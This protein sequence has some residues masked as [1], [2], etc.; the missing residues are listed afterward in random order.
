MVRLMVAGSAHLDVIASVS[1]DEFTLDK[2]GTISIEVGGTACNIALNLLQLGAHVNFLTAMNNSPHAQFVAGYLGAQG[3]ELIIDKNQNL[4]L[5]AFSAHINLQG[6]LESAITATSIALHKFTDDRVE[7]ALRGV[8]AVVI[9]CNLSQETIWQIIRLATERLLPIFAAAVSEEKSLRILGITPALTAFFLNNRELSYIRNHLGS[10]ARHPSELNVKLG[11]TLVVTQGDQGAYIARPHCT[12][13][14]YIEAP[15]VDV[16]GNTLGMGDAFMAATVYGHIAMDQT[17]EQAA[18]AALPLVAQIA[19]RSNCNQSEEGGLD[20]VLHEMQSLARMDAMTGVLNRVS[21]EIELERMQNRAMR[22]GSPLSVAI[23]D[24]DFFK[25]VNDTYGH[26]QGDQ[27]IKRVAREMQA[28]VR[29]GDVVGRWGGEEFV[30][31]M[32]DSKIDEAIVA[33]ERIRQ[34]IEENVKEPRQITV[35]IGVAQFSGPAIDVVERADQ[36]LYVA[37]KTGRNQVCVQE[38]EKLLD[39]ADLA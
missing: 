32:P 15:I 16:I 23:L 36:G 31:L 37:K 26:A 35:S 3:A 1:G 20:R 12:D 21:C 13:L 18:N 24:I 28:S 8:D 5:S 22:I 39:C 6:E 2:I 27:V 11:T 30:I 9:D 14:S 19:N 38:E 17:L 4:P 34:R 25:S 29:G 7:E 33:A 10:K